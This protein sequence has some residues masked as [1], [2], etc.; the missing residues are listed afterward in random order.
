M[1]L[2]RFQKELRTR[3][4]PPL[5]PHRL[6][7]SREQRGQEHAKKGRFVPQ[8]VGA[9]PFRLV[10]RRERAVPGDGNVVLQRRR[11]GDKEHSAVQELQRHRREVRGRLGHLRERPSFPARLNKL[12]STR[13]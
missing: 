1:Q 12:R 13:E 11:G 3:R 7:A 5:S 9:W 10:L 2:F 8:G 6:V 4:T